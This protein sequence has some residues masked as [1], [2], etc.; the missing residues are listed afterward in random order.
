MRRRREVEKMYVHD[1]HCICTRTLHEVTCSLA[2]SLSLLLSLP[3]PHIKRPWF[4]TVI[5]VNQSYRQ[6]W[7]GRNTFTRK[8]QS[9]YENFGP[10]LESC[11]AL[12]LRHLTMVAMLH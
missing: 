12:V 1:V 8:E 2:H 9:R 7:S 4:V 10:S 11:S 5:L 3:L 6:N